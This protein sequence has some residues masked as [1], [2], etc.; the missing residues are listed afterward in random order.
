MEF[1]PFPAAVLLILL[2]LVS[3]LRLTNFFNGFSESSWLAGWVK[4]YRGLETKWTWPITKDFPWPSMVARRN[5]GLSSKKICT[6]GNGKS[7]ATGCVSAAFKPSHHE[8]QPA[9]HK[10]WEMQNES[11]KIFIRKT[12][13]NNSGMQKTGP[14]Q[15]NEH[16]WS[17]NYCCLL[18]TEAELSN[19]FSTVLPLKKSI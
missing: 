7:V 16:T 15:N 17:F 14:I 13:C 11:Y 1:V 19:W 3:W 4:E 18:S 10:L 8:T 2:L 12:S 5:A 6:L 9:S